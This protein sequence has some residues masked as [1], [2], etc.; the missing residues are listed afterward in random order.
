[1]STDEGS[2]DG[3]YV[4]WETPEVP[5]RGLHGTRLNFGL[6][7]ELMARP[8]AEERGFIVTNSNTTVQI[9]VPYN[10]EGGYRKVRRLFMS[11]SLKWAWNSK[12]IVIHGCL[13]GLQII[14]LVLLI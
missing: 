12:C 14:I 7:G 11:R 13:K 10:A 9:S 3:G 8:V 5:C 6:N 4:M 1:M 2:Y